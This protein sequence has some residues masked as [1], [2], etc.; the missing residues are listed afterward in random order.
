M[1][2]HPYAP[3]C[4]QSQSACCDLIEFVGGDIGRPGTSATAWSAHVPSLPGLTELVVNSNGRFRNTTQDGD[5]ADV[6]AENLGRKANLTGLVMRSGPGRPLLAA[7][8]AV[9]SLEILTDDPI[10]PD[11][12]WPPC[13]VNLCLW[14]TE[15]GKGTPTCQHLSSDASKRRRGMQGSLF[16]LDMATWNYLLRSPPHPSLWEPCQARQSISSPRVPTC[17]TLPF[18]GFMSAPWSSLAR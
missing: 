17:A 14:R 2:D 13:L 1:S 4:H 5:D 3:R 10:G 16:F 8:S 11:T 6:L 9:V 7:L 18:G 12:V 15:I